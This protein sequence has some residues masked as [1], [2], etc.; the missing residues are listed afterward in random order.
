V[1]LGYGDEEQ[2]RA[3][4]GLRVRNVAGGGRL[5]DLEGKVSGIE[6][7]ATGTFTS[8]QIFTSRLD[9]VASGGWI[10]R[11]LPSFTDQSLYTM[12]RLERHGFPGNF[13]G[14]PA[15]PLNTPGPSTF[16]RPP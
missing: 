10:R 5:L 8:P 11:E 7:R 3:R 14:T 15:T 6:T 13:G 12:T 2:L 16:R 4:L 9:F 1:G